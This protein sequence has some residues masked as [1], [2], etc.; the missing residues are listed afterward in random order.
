MSATD[1][2]V[3]NVVIGH[4]HLK[5]D[6]TSVG[7]INGGLSIQKATDVY[8]VYVDQLLTPIRLKPTKETFLVKTNLS[9]STLTNLRYAWNIPASKLTGTDGQVGGTLKIG[10]STGVV[11]HT[12][13]IT[14]VAPNGITRVIQIFRAVH[15]TASEFA[16]QQNKEV[17]FPVQFTCLADTT[18]PVG[19]ELAVIVDVAGSL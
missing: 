11:E 4:G 2:N 5:V 13:E 14:G 10:V 18:K 9:E 19:E 1:V 3:S 17:M 6:G 7:G 12:L 16:F 8:E 15:L